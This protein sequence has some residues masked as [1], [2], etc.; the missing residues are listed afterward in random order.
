MATTPVAASSARFPCSPPPP[1]QQQQQQQQAAMGL[2]AEWVAEFFS[3]SH[4]I[5]PWLFRELLP[6][7]LR[8][9]SA[10]VLWDVLPRLRAALQ[11]RE[12]PPG[13]LSSIRVLARKRDDAEMRRGK[14]K[15]RGAEGDGEEGVPRWVRIVVECC[16]AVRWDGVRWDGMCEQF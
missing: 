1:Q 5:S 8:G 14:T 3:V 16:T 15:G 2:A 4:G 6:R 7:P 9:D 13:L 10:L 12:L 11:D